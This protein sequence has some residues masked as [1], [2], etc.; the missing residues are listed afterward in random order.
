[1]LRRTALEDAVFKTGERI[2]QAVAS[3]PFEWEGRTIQVTVSLGVAS[4]HA[5]ENVPD[6]M[7]RRADEALYRAKKAGKNKVCAED[8]NDR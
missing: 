1:M 7:V 5:G 3:A 4:L 2:R 8:E 6:L